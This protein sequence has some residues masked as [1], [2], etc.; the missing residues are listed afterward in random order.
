MKNIKVTGKEIV[1]YIYSGGDLT[2]EFSSN[3]RALE[4][5]EV[6][7]FIQNQ[8]DEEDQKEVSVET[9]FELDNYSFH[10]TGR[11]DGL[12][13]VDGKLMIEEIKSTKLDLSIME[14]DTRP[15]H[16]MQA[17]MYAYMYCNEHN[18]KSINVRL[19]Y[20]TV[21]EYKVK[22]FTKRYSM[23]QL[24]KFFEKTMFEYVTWLRIYDE[25]QK[26]KLTSL[27]GLSFPFDDYREGQYK[28]M[29]AV[30][31]T[32]MSKD[33][34]YSIAPT[35]IGKT[36][37]SLYSSLKTISNEKEKIFYLTAKNAGKK[38][39]VDTVNLLKDNGL[40]CKT[41]VIN[42]KE[43]MCLKDKVDCDPDICEYA[44]GYFDRLKDALNDIFVHQDVY[45]MKLIKDYGEFHKICPHEFSLSISNFSDVVICDYNYA[46]DPRTH[47]IRYFEE[48]YYSP[49]LLIDE[50]HNMVDRSRSMYSSTLSKEAVINLRKA[51]SKVKP[52][53]RHSINKLIKYIEDFVEEN[54]VEKARFYYQDE[55][56]IELLKLVDRIINK[57][58]Q[59]LS[60]NK[61]FQNRDKV[62]DGYFELL[63]FSRISDYYNSDY[64]YVLES[65]NDDI[66]VTQ[67]CLDA[68]TYIL[69]I[70]E[71]RA[72]GAVFFS[73]TLDPIDYYVK[74]I[75]KG[76]GKSVRIASPFKQEHLGL[77]VDNNTST[78]YRDRDRSVDNIIDTIY[79]MLE[80][81]VGN[82][83]AFFP[84]YH[85]MDMI[86]EQFDQENYN[87]YIQKRNMSQRERSKMLDG[88]SK[89]DTESKIGFFV[90]GGSFSEGVD[91]IGDML[92]GVL[93]VGVAMPMFNKQNELLR[94]HFDEHFDEGFD[95]AY[96]Y[97][98]M[99]KVVQAVGRVIRTEK[100][101]GIAILFDDRYTHRKYLEL[102]PKH[103]NHF[104]II[105]KNDFVQNKIEK[106]WK[107]FTNGESKK[108]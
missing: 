10:I 12:L 101:K 17:K 91:Y 49:K 76:E 39:V 31:Q 37:G 35:G 54:E 66:L 56:D 65:R 102:Y 45:D 11:M 30:Y 94:S 90:L 46:F 51:T 95:Y 52:S 85:Y 63:Q 1:E 14:I 13:K 43:S 33:V 20:V 103:W 28:F 97:P 106:F 25:H 21:N 53:P 9:L 24:T 69:D 47:L 64:K 105:R 108:I 42:S 61:K 18:L 77:F 27:E 50:A 62:L 104:N 2:S 92:S 67:M 19:K 58:D 32:F 71:R 80:T 96:T 48:D 22:E 100:D 29:G 78:R 89:T 44:K 73:A 81:K 83:I 16:M 41:V 57:L 68:S 7:K 74:L 8:Y 36:I 99:N 15:E 88:F 59:I 40:V 4:G 72:S 60:E 34:L 70:I 26:N 75:T 5:I 3:K 98:G 23:T 87:C 107:R 93:I 86:L 55:L 38:I 84:S 82:Y 6:H 79:A